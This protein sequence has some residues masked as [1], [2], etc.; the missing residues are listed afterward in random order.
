MPQCSDAAPCHALAAALRESSS[1]MPASERPRE[2]WS[3]S[4]KTS[5]QAPLTSTSAAPVADKMRR[6]AEVHVLPSHRFEVQ[7]T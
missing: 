3:T 1:A 4:L 2:L 6:D 5:G 7:R